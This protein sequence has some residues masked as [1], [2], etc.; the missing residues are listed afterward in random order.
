MTWRRK[1]WLA[2][3]A[4]VVVALAFVGVQVLQA[5]SAELAGATDYLSR[6]NWGWIALAVVAEAA[7]YVNTTF[8]QRRLLLA[9]GLEVPLPPLAAM[10]LAG[11]AIA[12]SLPG[13]GAFATVFAYRQF[14]RRGADEALTTWSLIAFTSVTSVTLGVLAVIGLLVAG[15]DS[16]VPGLWL[17]VGLLMLAPVIGMTVLLRPRLARPVLK[18]VL[19]WAKRLTGRPREDPVAH[20]DRLI[21]HLEAV[22]P[23]ARDWVLCLAFAGGNWATDCLCLVM[24]FKAVGATVPWRGLLVAYGAA[25]VAASLPVTPGGLGVVEGS[26]TVA[27]VAFGGSTVQTVAAV[28]LYRILSFWLVVPLGWLAWAGL[29]LEGRR[30]ALKRVVAP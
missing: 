27:L 12:N 7:S 25:Q 19:G 1:L 10:S 6:A 17:L 13:G 15:S 9:G 18:P 11:N 23:R 4:L 5:N 26:L 3:R 29:N 22:K 24:A 20:V 28:L 14:R 16:G 21:S 8:L 30:L 2:A